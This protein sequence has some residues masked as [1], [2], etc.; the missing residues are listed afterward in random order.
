[1]Y[2]LWKL[3]TR[4]EDWFSV[5]DTWYIKRASMR[6]FAWQ[7]KTDL[8]LRL[9]KIENLNNQ[10]TKM[11]HLW[12]GLCVLQR[13]TGLFLAL[14]ASDRCNDWTPSHRPCI[15]IHLEIFWEKG[16]LEF[17]IIYHISNGNFTIFW[18]WVGNFQRCG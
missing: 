4:N 16:I 3:N 14:R 15:S 11:K 5:L 12:L 2:I 13:F 18:S 7:N 10:K 6:N 1:M 9:L 17:Q 8:R